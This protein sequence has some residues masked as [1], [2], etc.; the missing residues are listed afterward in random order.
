MDISRASFSWIFRTSAD[1]EGAEADESPARQEAKQESNHPE[2][3]TGR[4]TAPNLASEQMN[5]GLISEFEQ[6]FLER[7]TS[8]A[9]K[10]ICSRMPFFTNRCADLS[11]TTFS[12]RW[13]NAN[14]RHKLPRLQR[15]TFR[16][17][18]LKLCDSSASRSELSTGGKIRHQLCEKFETGKLDG[19]NLQSTRADEVQNS[20]DALWR[21][22]A[23]RATKK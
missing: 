8:R 3:D 12:T 1:A 9:A 2:S 13:G 11:A 10:P 23:A 20:G 16:M 5:Q 21:L 22:D 4:R 17:A 14:S 18:D 19:V 15:S 6:I 7:R